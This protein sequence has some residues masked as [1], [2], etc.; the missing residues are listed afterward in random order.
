MLP[1]LL[2]DRWMDRLQHR[3]TAPEGEV[4]GCGPVGWGGGQRCVL[5]PPGEAW[6]R[7]PCLQHG[8][9]GGGHLDHDCGHH[10]LAASAG[11]RGGGAEAGGSEPGRQPGHPRW[12][13]GQN[14]R[15]RSGV[16][17]RGRQR[18]HDLR[19]EPFPAGEVQAQVHLDSARTLRLGPDQEAHRFRLDLFGRG[20]AISEWR[21]A[22]EVAAHGGSQE[23]LA[24]GCV[25]LLA[26]AP[27]APAGR[28]L[29]VFGSAK[30]D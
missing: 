26:L 12:P 3:S 18:P 5:Q 24:K 15:G 17:Q 27:L 23:V 11:H 20:P 25:G 14:P 4:Y 10:R 30:S 21:S 2:H 28:Q 6:R 22:D 9:Q 8:G 1:L 16:S 29:Q 7:W 13:A 19:R